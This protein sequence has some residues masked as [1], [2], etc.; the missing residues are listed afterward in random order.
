MEVTPEG[1]ILRE[2][3][4][5]GEDTWARFSRQIDYRK[6]PTTK[7]H[8]SH[9]NFAFLL[10]GDIWTTRCD[11]KDAICLT[12]RAHR[13]TRYSPAALPVFSRSKHGNI[14]CHSAP[15]K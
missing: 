3:S 6:V 15:C 2:W 7:P 14:S 8:R 5:I 13:P 12:G 10:E 4:V 11:Q 9:P 1:E